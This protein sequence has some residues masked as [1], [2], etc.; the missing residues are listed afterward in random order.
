[1][2]ANPYQP[3]SAKLID[4]SVTTTDVELADRGQR[5]GASILDAIIGLAFGIPIMLLLGTLD[6]IRRAQQLPL[7]VTIA[8]VVLGFVGF[9]LLHGYYLKKGGQTIGKKIVGIRIADLDNNIP[10]IGKILG[11]RYLPIQVAA[12]IP[13]VGFVYPLVDVLFIFRQDRR[14]IHDLIAGTRVVKV[15]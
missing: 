11:L 12:L 7:S 5:F 14:C 4:E 9:V 2:E 3:P 15:K 8:S 6:Y 1:V 10:P 13:I